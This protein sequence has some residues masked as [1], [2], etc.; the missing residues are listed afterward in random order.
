MEVFY[1][2]VARFKVDVNGDVFIHGI[3]MEVS[4]F[5]YDVTYNAY[6]GFIM[7]M[8]FAVLPERSQSVLSGVRV[9]CEVESATFEFNCCR[10]FVAGVDILF[11]KE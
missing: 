11:Y 4:A 6:F 9:F 5:D 2:Y 10:I 3:G 7:D 8:A 1:T